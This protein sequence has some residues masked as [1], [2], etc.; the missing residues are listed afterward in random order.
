MI[1]SA[2]LALFLLL[3][4]LLLVWVKTSGKIYDKTKGESY[5]VFTLVLQ[6]LLNHDNWVKSKN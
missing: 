6:K 1:Q 5:Y 2:D 3:L 4:F